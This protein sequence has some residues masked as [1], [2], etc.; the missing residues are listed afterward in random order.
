VR[1]DVGEDVG[2]LGSKEKVIIRGR[3]RGKKT[4]RVINQRRQGWNAQGGRRERW[5]E[6]F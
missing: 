1:E 6:E 4:K 3:K 2:E 5:N